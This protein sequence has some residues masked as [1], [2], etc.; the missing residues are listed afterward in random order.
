MLG[1]SPSVSV[2]TTDLKPGRKMAINM[3]G[4]T[5]MLCVKGEA[6]VLLNFKQRKVSRGDFMLLEAETSLIP[7]HISEDFSIR[8]ASLPPEIADEVAYRM[9]SD[10][11]LNYTECHPISHVNIG[12]Y[13][14]LSEWFGQME[15]IAR[16]ADN[17]YRQEMLQGHLLHLYMAVDS[18]I[19]RLKV[20]PADL[21]EKNRGWMLLNRFL[22]LLSKYNLHNREVEF[23]AGKLCIT[24]DY[25]HKLCCKEIGVSPKELINKQSV[26]IIKTYLSST[27]WSV[28]TIA[29]EL[30]FSDT[31]HL[32]RFFR[33]MTGMSPIEFRNKAGASFENL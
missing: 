10:T 22:S 27:D 2:G 29:A 15:W 33:R 17:D 8:F 16:F 21:Q 11:F 3:N 7:L 12:Q 19:R 9:T 18:E 20:Y 28:K 13:R 23:Y 25:L 1:T 5:V 26:M 14:M 24:S 30:N 4:C 31:S 32:C 6:T